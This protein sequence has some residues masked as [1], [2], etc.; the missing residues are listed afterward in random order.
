MFSIL[1]PNLNPLQSIATPARKS[2]PLPSILSR[3]HFSSSPGA[4]T[5]WCALAGHFPQLISQS[6][7]HTDYSTSVHELYHHLDS[8]CQSRLHSSCIHYYVIWPSSVHINLFNHYFTAWNN[9]S[10]SRWWRFFFHVMLYIFHFIF[11]RLLHLLPLRS[12]P[13]A[14]TATKFFLLT[15]M[16]REGFFLFCV[17]SV[18]LGFDFLM[19]FKSRARSLCRLWSIIQ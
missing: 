15:T 17:N 11:T 7:I 1:S 14:T 13:L 6:N 8:R 5:T 9:G 16:Q 2:S 10:A 12:L 19:L 3:T 4:I 18:A